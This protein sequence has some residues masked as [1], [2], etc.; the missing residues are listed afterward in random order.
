[1]IAAALEID[2]YLVV[3]HFFVLF[4]GTSFRVWDAGG[5]VECE[6]RSDSM[7][8]PIAICARDPVMDSMGER[9]GACVRDGGADRGRKKKPDGK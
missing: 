3:V 9:W 6:W 8:P 7:L 2:L 1:M 4:P 5:V